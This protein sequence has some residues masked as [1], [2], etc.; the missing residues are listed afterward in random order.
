MKILLKAKAWQIFMITIGLP[1]IFE[2]IAIPFL[3]SDNP[4]FVM[5]AIPL[6]SILCIIGF[7]CW[8]WS[9]A[10]GLQEKVPDGVKLKVIRF[11][12]FFFIPLIYFV[13]LFSFS[14]FVSNGTTEN[15]LISNGVAMARLMGVTFPLHLFSMFCI[16]YCLYFVAK[17][18]KTVELQRAVTF[19]DFAGE[20]FLIWFFPV[21]IWII[22]PRINKMVENIPS[23]TE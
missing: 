10:V 19:S 23:K 14:A 15:G 21:G 6:I 20:F 7:L 3:V 16:F 8:F 9:I 18:F 12:A 5:I 17:T 4:L 1:I 22:Q 13:F 11:K 2:I